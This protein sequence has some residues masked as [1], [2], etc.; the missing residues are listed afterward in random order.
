MDTKHPLISFII[1]VYK[2]R[3]EVLENCLKSLRDMSY[4]RIEIIVVFDGPPEDAELTSI[5]KKWTGTD[6]ILEVE[7]G[8]AP[9]AR[10]AGAKLA[11]GQYLS[12]WD[13][14][15]YAKPEMAKRWIQEFKDTDADFVYSGYEFTGHTGG[16]NGEPFDPYLLTCNNYISTMFPMRREVFPGFDE[17]LK[18]A[19][20]WDLWLSIV[21]KGG[22]GSFIEG[23]GF[24]T[25][26]PSQ[27]SISGKEWSSEKFRETHWKV[28]NKHNIQKRD[29]V[30]GSE[31]EKLKGLHIAKLI[32]ADFSQ[33]LDFRVN[34]YKLAFNLRFGENIW[35]K[36]AP[37]DCVKIQYWMPWDITGLENWGFLKS[38]EM[39]KKLKSTK[40]MHHWVN[41]TLSQ[42]RLGKLFE[43]VGL[44]APTIVPLPSE[45]EDAEQTLPQDYRVLLDIDDAYM[46]FLKTIK[47]DLPYLKI[48]DLNFQSNPIAPVNQYSMLVSFKQY[49]TVDEPIRRMLIN[50]R[51]IISNTQ[52]PYCG[53][54]DLDV[55]MKEFKQTLIRRIRDGRVL[56]FNQEAAEHYKKEVDP[57]AFGERIKA[58]LPVALEVR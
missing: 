1:P 46:P 38:V 24:I 20:D 21:E 42:K 9:K 49:P 28:R 3:P 12:F 54:F 8:G 23:F 29:I 7:H 6:K 22:K 50:G 43:F 31:M 51:N 16:V 25:E 55:T 14:D 37:A 53:Y 52:A 44:E 11:I 34:D 56:P 57:M 15:S 47:Q 2:T 10:N 41:E 13:S 35:F 40:N 33:F 36:N 26:P 18:A 32:E 19:Q 48:D 27:E 5:A 45:V 17:T 4:K 39:L 58:L 30:I